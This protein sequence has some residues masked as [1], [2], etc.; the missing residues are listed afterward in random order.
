MVSMVSLATC[1]NPVADNS[2]LTTPSDVNAYTPPT[3]LGY[4]TAS[5]EFSEEMD[6]GYSQ[7]QKLL[8]FCHL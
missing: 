5:L 3:P 7:T 4:P 1:L 2:F 8:N 6:L